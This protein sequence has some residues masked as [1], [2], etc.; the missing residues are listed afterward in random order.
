MDD[1]LSKIDI[2]DAIE[3]VNQTIPKIKNS[4]V[5]DQ[6]S[7]LK[8]HLEEMKVAQIELEHV[9]EEFHRG[10][11]VS[12]IYLDRHKK[13]VRD[14]FIARDSIPEDVV[15]NIASL[16]DSD[17]SKTGLRKWGGL[18]R[19][20]RNFVLNLTQFLLNVVTLFGVH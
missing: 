10:N 19:E 20:N 4:S 11:L 1:S 2:D 3:K 14:Y 12:E 7:T 15:P 5:I 6:L 17:E 13:L 16:I 18:L 8:S 9:E